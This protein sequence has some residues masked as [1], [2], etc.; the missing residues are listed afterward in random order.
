MAI[1]QA[2]GVPNLPEKRV[3]RRGILKIATG[4]GAA[5][6]LAAAGRVIVPFLA[7]DGGGEP[8][9]STQ[10]L[11]QG[12]PEGE[13]TPT[14]G[15]EVSPTATNTVEPTK[16]PEAKIYPV[17]SFR[18]VS[19]RLGFRMGVNET[20]VELS[21][22]KD[23]GL[24]EKL[25]GD[26]YNRLG[27]VML[28]SLIMAQRDS[29]GRVQYNF[30]RPDYVNKYGRD[31]KMDMVGEHL[32]WWSSPNFQTPVIKDI[33][34]RADAESLLVEQTNAYLDHY[35][36]IKKWTV[37][38]YGSGR[39]PKRVDVMKELYGEDYMYKVAEIAK[40]RDPN[41]QIFYS[42]T[43]NEIINTYSDA[44]LA[45]CQEGVKRGLIDGMYFQGGLLTFDKHIPTEDEMTKNFERFAALKNGKFVI[46]FSEYDINL[47][48][49]QGTQEERWK[50]EADIGEASLRAILAVGG[51]SLAVNNANDAVS[52]LNSGSGTQSEGTFF[53]ANGN[54]KPI[55]DRLLTVLESEA[56]KR[57]K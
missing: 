38:E 30:Q 41:I 35:P 13:G 57:G 12:T 56:T 43:R 10:P 17:G 9:P 14:P 3:S 50:L 8:D 49:I 27:I 25:V 4:I 45:F 28:P 53:D 39:V 32:S 24:A 52:R 51:E 36:D 42:D 18:T 21:G 6:A 40:T 22:L 33:R 19:D 2:P 29:R 44:D 23:T 47:S 31:H 16:T 15:T 54:P 26:Q 55:R 34:T 37:N 46:G 20:F 7:S 48:G 1:E 11:T 5:G